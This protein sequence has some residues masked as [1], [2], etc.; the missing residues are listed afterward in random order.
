MVTRHIVKGV[1]ASLISILMIFVVVEC[2]LRVQGF[3]E[4]QESFE[5]AMSELPVLDP[6]M[7][8]WLGAAIQPSSNPDIVYELRPDMDVELVGGIV[9]TNSQ[10]F[11]TDREFSI[12]KPPGTIRIVGI[13][14]SFMFGYGVH[15]DQEMLKV[16]EG[17]LNDRYPERD[18]EAI[19]T[20][21]P[22]YNTVMEVATLE[23]KALEYG[24]DLVVIEFIGNDTHLPNF[25]YAT[26]DWGNFRTSY[27]L[28]FI[29]DKFRRAESHVRSMGSSFL[30]AAPLDQDGSMAFEDDPKRVP[31]KYREMVG[32]AAY[33]RS[34]RRLA[35]LRDEHGFEV[36]N[37]L[38]TQWDVEEVE[39]LSRELGFEVVRNSTYDSSDLS[40][41][42]SATDSHASAKGHDKNAEHFIGFMDGQGI[43]ARLMARGR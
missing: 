30:T 15:Q 20:A 10:G 38:T 6:G 4:E 18:W 16:L 9:R 23:E 24:P 42:I 28:E 41:V 26:K 17:K 25:L 34:L 13:G 32:W 11:R 40:L 29:Q 8:V 31:P 2:A 36:I 43:I 22:G 37:L 33:E 12:E 21:V 39:G 14:D 5:K 27:F 1:S 3:F 7:K 19:N 35:E